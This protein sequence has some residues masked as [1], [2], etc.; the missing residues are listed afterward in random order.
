MKANVVP[1]AIVVISHVIEGHYVLET[2]CRDF[3]HF[4]ALPQVVEF[5]GRLCGKTGWSSD[6]GRACYKSDVSI[7][8]AVKVR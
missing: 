7:A 3:E 2:T 8:H 6:T 5:Q 1:D 4:I